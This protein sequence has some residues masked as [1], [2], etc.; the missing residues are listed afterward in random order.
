RGAPFIGVEPIL[1]IDPDPGQLLP[2]PPELVAAPRE[3]LL[4]LE[5]LEPRREPLF[6]CPGLV[7]WHGCFLRCHEPFLSTRIWDA[8]RQ[9]R[10]AAD[11]TGD[12]PCRNRRP[13]RTMCRIRGRSARRRGGTPRRPAANPQRRDSPYRR[14]NSY[15]A[16]TPCGNANR[17]T[18]RRRAAF[19]GRRAMRQQGRA[20]FEM[21]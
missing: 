10:R 19:S 14:R 18:R 12:K 11:R 1:L 9:R 2:A 21:R 13:R 7:C 16:A 15:P 17:A 20:V 5:Q 4:R 8:S 3:F 6:A